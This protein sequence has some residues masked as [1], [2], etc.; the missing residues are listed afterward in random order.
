VLRA[1]LRQRASFEGL[2]MAWFDARVAYL[3]R[4]PRTLV[5]V[6]IRTAPTLLFSQVRGFVRWTGWRAEGAMTNQLQTARI[7]PVAFPYF[8]ADY[9]AVYYVERW[10]EVRT[11][12]LR[13]ALGGSARSHGS[14]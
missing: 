6:A 4:H 3:G 12:L 8:A 2:M 5:C 9:A 1:T 13:G 14:L 10:A 7:T 11:R